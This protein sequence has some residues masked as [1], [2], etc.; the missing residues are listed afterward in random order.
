MQRVPQTRLHWSAFLWPGLPQLWLR[1]SWVGLALAVGFTAL[2]NVLAASTLVWDEWLPDRARTIGLGGLAAIWIIASIDAR[3]EW[4]RLLSEWSS[5]E[6]TSAI[7]DPRSDQWFRE[8]QAAY[9]AGDWVSAEKTLLKLLQLDA[10]DAESRLML[11]TLWRHERRFD[12]A[13]AEFD[14]LERLETSAQWQ[15]EISRE[16]ERI[17]ASY[18]KT[19][20]DDPPATPDVLPAQTELG[21]RRIESTNRRRAA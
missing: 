17:C 1:G 20:P 9:L 19:L 8:A 14:R 16:R 7:P 2:A 10:R 6:T 4:R 11:A 21:D 5:D 15:F 12:A 18:V 3:A 13:T